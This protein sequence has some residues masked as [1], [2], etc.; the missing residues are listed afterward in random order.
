MPFRRRSTT[1]HRLPLKAIAMK[2]AHQPSPMTTTSLKMTLTAHFFLILTVCSCS[3]FVNPAATRPSSS[4]TASPTALSIRMDLEHEPH[5]DRILRRFR[6]ESPTFMTTTV[7]PAKSPRQIPSPSRRVLRQFGFH[8][9]PATKEETA[10]EAVQERPAFVAPSLTVPFNINNISS[11]KAFEIDPDRLHPSVIQVATKHGMPWTSSMSTSSSGNVAQQP[12]FL[13]FWQFQL[14]FMSKHLTNL[15]G[16]PSVSRPSNDNKDTSDMSYASN[17]SMRMHTSQFTSDEYKN[18]RMTFMDGDKIQVFTSV[19]YPQPHLNLPILACDF[20]MFGKGDKKRLVCICDLQ[21]IQEREQDHDRTYEHLLE[22]IRNQYPSLQCEMTDRFYN[23]E[24]QFFSSQILLSR[25]GGVDGNR[26]DTDDE[27]FI[28][29]E[30][31]PAY[32]QYM[33]THVDLVKSVDKDTNDKEEIAKVLER[34]TV[35]DTYCAQRDP[36]HPMLARAFGQDFADSYMYD[37]LFPL[38]DRKQEST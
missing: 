28:F 2:K 31:F 38:A 24:D 27:T 10:N 18:I 23:S 16:I 4:S 33:K 14:H 8:V 32:T 15:R 29:Q 25:R 37:I 6:L 11:S 19:W 3:A 17:D 1:P 35:Y 7:N 20:L 9:A 36:A 30:L 26:E 21:P 22:P 5:N 34:H 12:Y 13:P